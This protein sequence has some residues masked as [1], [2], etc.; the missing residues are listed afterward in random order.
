MVCS[1]GSPHADAVQPLD[2]RDLAALL[3]TKLLNPVGENLARSLAAADLSQFVEQTRRRVVVGRRASLDEL[4]D[5]TPRLVL[6]PR[7]FA[8]VILAGTFSGATALL[9]PSLDVLPSRTLS[10]FAA[11]PGLREQILRGPAG[12]V[13]GRDRPGRP[14]AAGPQFDAHLRPVTPG[15]PQ[16]KCVLALRR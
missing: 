12:T 6:P 14:P 3:P 8:Q 9:F 10:V 2:E 11:P 1:V 4:D 7:E 16:Q 15:D 13:A 5:L